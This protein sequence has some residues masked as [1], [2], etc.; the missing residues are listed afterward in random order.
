M[1]TKRPPPVTSTAPGSTDRPLVV[2]ACACGASYTVAEWR[3]LH[4]LGY[5]DSEGIEVLEL[6]N[7]HCRSTIGLRKWTEEPIP[8]PIGITEREFLADQ[9]GRPPPPKP[10]GTYIGR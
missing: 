2:A 5:W 6:R 4:F 8:E 3:Q 1:A 10:R 9:A 7:C